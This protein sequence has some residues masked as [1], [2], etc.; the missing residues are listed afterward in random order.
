MIEFSDLF[1][2]QSIV[3]C[4]DIL[5]PFVDILQ[6]FFEQLILFDALT[7]IQIYCLELWKLELKLRDSWFQLFRGIN[8]IDVFFAK[9]RNSFK[10]MTFLLQKTSLCYFLLFNGLVQVHIFNSGTLEFNEG[11]LFVLNLRLM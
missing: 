3:L 1:V 6:L 8:V 5:F 11:F 10:E 2:Y 9:M 4:F 7:E